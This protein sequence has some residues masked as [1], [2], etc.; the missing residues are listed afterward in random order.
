MAFRRGDY[1]VLVMTNRAESVPAE[2][3]A[4]LAADLTR[5]VARASLPAGDTGPYTFPGTPSKLVGSGSD[6]GASSP[7]WPAARRPSP[8]SGRDGSGGAGRAARSR[9]PRLP[10]GPARGA[11]IALDADAKRLRRQ[12][13]VVAGGQL[14][15]VNISI[16][17]LAGDFAWTGIA[18]A[19]AAFLA[20][21]AVTRWWQRRELG[22]LGS[23]A[24]PREFVR[25]RPGGSRGRGVRAGGPRSRR[26]IRVQRPPLPGL[27]ADTGATQVGRPVRRRAPY[28][29]HHLHHRRV[30]GG[31]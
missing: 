7:P 15:A 30:R 17:A 11:A 2:R 25:P 16:V 21:L 27:S 28:G 12:G 5:L 24:P 14:T 31:R 3:A 20:G 4:A 6:G 29:R 18:V 9:R 8:A 22:L 19:V 26:R 13:A 23:K 1:F 10:M